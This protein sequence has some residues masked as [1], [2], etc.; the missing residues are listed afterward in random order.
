MFEK[1]R[2]KLNQ[3]Q[4]NPLTSL[5]NTLGHLVVWVTKGIFDGTVGPMNQSNRFVVLGIK[6]VMVV[7]EVQLR[8]NNTDG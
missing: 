5:V 1:G 4:Q 6:P 8:G 7:V 3:F 2:I